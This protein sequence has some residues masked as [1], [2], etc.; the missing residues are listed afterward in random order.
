MNESELMEAIKKAHPDAKVE[1]TLDDFKDVPFIRDHPNPVRILVHFPSGYG[2][3]I[4]R[5]E[6]SYGGNQG[7][8]ELAVLMFLPDNFNYDIIYDTPI[9]NDV[10]GFLEVN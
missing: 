3:S 4:I 2:A 10:R 8:L 5:N 7:L 1:S 6:Y 9:T